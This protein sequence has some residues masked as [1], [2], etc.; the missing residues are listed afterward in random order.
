MARKCLF[1]KEE[2]G[3]V[4]LLLLFSSTWLLFIAWG[5]AIQLATKLLEADTSSGN[6]FFHALSPILAAS[7]ALSYGVIFWVGLSMYLDWMF[8]GVLR[9]W[10]KNVGK[11]FA[12]E[13]DEL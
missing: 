6:I 7:I 11:K 9:G 10:I 8:Y 13:D 3:L 5:G 2:L 1:G 12:R 4:G